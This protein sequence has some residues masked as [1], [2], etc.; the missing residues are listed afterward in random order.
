[1]SAAL[2]RLRLLAVPVSWLLAL[3]IAAAVGAHLFWRFAAPPR[4]DLPVR[5][6]SDPRTVAQRIAGQQPFGG[7]APVPL[8]AGTT[9][10]AT[11]GYTL[12]GVATGFAGGAAFAL[13][14][15]GSGAAEPFVEGDEI[16]TGVRLK[17]I[18]ANAVE[19]ERGGRTER[20]ELPASPTTGIVGA[21]TNPAATAAAPSSALAR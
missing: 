1:M 18:L 13:L 10:A 4:V 12:V 17:R 2:R 14:K 20:V 11:S 5:I 21:E 16:A 15:S 7:A 3:A 9:A 19:L 8:A 6:D